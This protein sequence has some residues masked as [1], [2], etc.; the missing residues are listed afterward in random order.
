MDMYVQPEGSSD[1]KKFI[2]FLRIK[3]NSFFMQIN[4][5][6]DH[7]TQLCDRGNSLVGQYKKVVLEI[8][9]YI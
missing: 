4:G 2:S 9:L 1:T 8:K 7:K 6:L 5:N 3:I